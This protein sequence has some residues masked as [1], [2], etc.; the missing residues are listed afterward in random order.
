MNK[1]EVKIKMWLNMTK[2]FPR[3]YQNAVYLH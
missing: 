2:N 3:E 1:K